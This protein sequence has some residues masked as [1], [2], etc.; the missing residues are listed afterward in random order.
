MIRVSPEFPCPVCGKD[1][2]CLLAPD[3]KAAICQRVSDGAIK[4]AGNAGWLHSTNGPKIAAKKER[5]RKVVAPLN[6][7]KLQALYRKQ[8][9]AAGFDVAGGYAGLMDRVEAGYCDPYFT[10]PMYTVGQGGLTLVGLQRV[11][12][13]THLKAF[14]RG[15][16]AG[17]F[18]GRVEQAG[19]WLIVTEGV[20]DTATAAS[21]DIAFV[22]GLPSAGVC[23][24]SIIDLAVY[25]EYSNVVIVADNDPP[26]LASARGLAE[27]LHRERICNIIVTPP[28]KDLREWAKH[29]SKDVIKQKILA[30]VE[31]MASR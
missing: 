9:L 3:G 14:M 13:T 22:A 29:E 5:K 23:R 18:W 1:D 17:I 31:N 11:N 28:C 25:H 16:Q 2:W 7:I 20:G 19:N 6:W 21:L 4:R 27:M 24:E 8:Y 12:E 15:S 10:V 26:G 30:C